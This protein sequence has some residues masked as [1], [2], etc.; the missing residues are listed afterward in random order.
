M[1]ELANYIKKEISGYK[2]LSFEIERKGMHIITLCFPGEG[3]DGLEMVKFK[4]L[5]GERYSIGYYSIY[6]AAEKTFDEENF[7][8]YNTK[9]KFAAE[10]KEW[11]YNNKPGVVIRDGEE[12]YKMAFLSVVGDLEELYE[13]IKFILEIFKEKSRNYIPIDQKE[14]F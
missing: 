2:Y 13:F 5:K 9:S 3:F 6:F 11:I 12:F 7:K 10:L 14:I 1:Q 4:I 8:K